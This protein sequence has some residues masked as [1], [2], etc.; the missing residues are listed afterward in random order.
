MRQSAAE[1]W[2]TREGSTT[3][4]LDSHYDLRLARVYNGMNTEEVKKLSRQLV[5]IYHDEATIDLARVTISHVA[6][7]YSNTKTPVYR[8]FIDGNVVKKNN[9]FKVTYTCITCDRLN[10]VALNNITRKMNRGMVFCASCR[11]LDEDKRRR[12]KDTWAL[13][14]TDG[15]KVTPP[16]PPLRE[17]LIEDARAFENMDDDFKSNYFRR[18]MDI[19]EFTYVRSKIISI[20]NNVDITNLCYYPCVSVS[21]QVRFNPYLYDPVEDTMVKIHRLNVRCDACGTCFIK[22]DII[23][24]KNRIKAL[25]IDCNLTNTVFKVRTY[26]NLRGDSIMYQ[27]KFELKFIR[28][29][30]ENNVLIT[31]GP[32]IPYT[33][34]GKTHFYRVDFFIPRLN[35]L[36]EIKDNHIW[37]K[38]QV[39]S[40]KWD[41]KMVGVSSWVTQE[42]FETIFPKNFVSKTKKIIMNNESKI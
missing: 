42:T 18:H 33:F 39:A 12:Q 31:N 6:H 13:K 27:S 3:T 10:D 28:K 37:H 29:C 38:Q 32:K 21:N 4:L 40:G 15:P 30:N 20:G 8:F 19:D 17:R 5:K 1:P 9:A 41:A 14:G 11:N 26:H 7:M 25:C 35:M 36:V 2:P 22:K 34:Q 16:H 24:L 23:T